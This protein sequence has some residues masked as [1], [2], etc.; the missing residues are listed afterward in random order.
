MGGTNKKPT[1]SDME[2][3]GQPIS[4]LKVSDVRVTLMCAAVS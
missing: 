4:E 3:V 1:Q 2:L